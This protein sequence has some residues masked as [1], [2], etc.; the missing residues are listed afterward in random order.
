MLLLLL[1]LSRF[2]SV[3]LCVTPE[4]TA[5]QGPPSL[6]FSRQE[7]WSGLPFSSPAVLFTLYMI[8]LV[9]TYII[10]GI[11]YFLI[12]FIH[13]NLPLAL[14]TTNLISLL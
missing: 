7:H 12:A 11:L 9:L 6:G 10:T 4:T 8:S 13:P 1:L 5:H 2:S 14:V 3:R